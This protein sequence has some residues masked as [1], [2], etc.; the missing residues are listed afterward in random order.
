[1]AAAPKKK[2]QTIEPAAAATAEPQMIDVVLKSLDESALVVGLASSDVD[3]VGVVLHR[4][5]G[6]FVHEKVGFR[7]G[8]EDVDDDVGRG[9]E[10]V[11][12][13]GRGGTSWRWTGRRRTRE[14][15]FCWFMVS[16][17]VGRDRSTSSPSDE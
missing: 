13:G 16:V 3:V 12:G 7:G 2:T 17:I 4:P 6:G 10:G 9:V 8:R 1:M 14:L 11:E 5:E 15:M